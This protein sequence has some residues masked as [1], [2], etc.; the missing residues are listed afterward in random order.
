MLLTPS[1]SRV[2]RDVVPQGVEPGHAGLGLAVLDDRRRRGRELHDVGVSPGWTIPSRDR[3]WASTSAGSESRARS[4]DRR[5]T[6]ASS[7][8]CRS[9]TSASSWRW[10]TKLCSGTATVSASAQT[11]MARMAARFVDDRPSSPVVR[12]TTSPAR[13]RARVRRGRAPCGPA[14]RDRAPEP[15]VDAGARAERAVVVRGL[16]AARPR[17]VPVVRARASRPRPRRSAMHPPVRPGFPHPPVPPVPLRGDPSSMPPDRAPVGVPRRT[18]RRRSGRHRC[19]RRGNDRSVSSGR[20]PRSAGTPARRCSG[21]RHR[22][23]PRCAAAGCTSPPARTAP[24]R[25]S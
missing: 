3:A 16:A 21:R 11:T 20:A 17:P 5:A 1:S 18:V 4:E 10:A 2:A 9:E 14:G 25:R 22:A 12:A 24:G 7:A 8:C 15:P 23:A 6:S 13:D 19:H